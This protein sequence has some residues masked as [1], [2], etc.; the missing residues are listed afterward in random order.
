MAVTRMREIRPGGVTALSAFFGCGAIIS[1]TAMLSLL[2]P[3]GWLEPMWQ[4]NP[5]ARLA[6]ASLSP[7]S[8]VLLCLV[9]AACGIAAVGLWRGTRWGYLT[10]RGLIAANLLGDVVNVV[11]GIEPR[12]AVGIPITTLMLLFLTTRRI[13]HY[14]RIGT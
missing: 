8:V 12:A 9:S 3:Q 11:T 6:F 4:L 1:F 5:R 7:W 14:F 2:T 13:R 10:G